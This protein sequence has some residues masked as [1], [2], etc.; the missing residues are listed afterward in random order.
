MMM[1]TI[2]GVAP[3]ISQL[4]ADDQHLLMH[5]SSGMGLPPTIFLT[6]K[7]RKL[8]IN[9]VY[10]GVC[11][12]DLLGELQLHQTFLRDVGI[13]P[14]RHK[15]FR[16]LILGVLP[17]KILEP[18]NLVFNYMYAILRL[19]CKYLEILASC[20]KS[21]KSRARSIARCRCKFR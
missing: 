21:D 6:I 4:V 3:K 20:C 7:L 1:M 18:K 8:A 5:T 15:K 2:R 17:P 13:S 10:F 16:H 11:R 9:W 12:R 19:Y 14:Q